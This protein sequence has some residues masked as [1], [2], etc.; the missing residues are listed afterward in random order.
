MKEN[1]KKLTANIYG[2]RISKNGKWLNLTI[3]THVNDKDVFITC[4]I[5][6]C[7]LGNPI[8]KVHAEISTD[9]KSASI[10]GVKVYTEKKPEE[11][12]Q[13]DLGGALEDGLPF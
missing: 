6:L 10:Y 2:S 1:K 11:P 13:D 12:K 9:G 4:P 5:R 8:D 3:V 7:E